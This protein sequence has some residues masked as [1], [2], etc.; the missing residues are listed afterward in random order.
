MIQGCYNW[1]TSAV[2]QMGCYQMLDQPNVDVKN[3]VICIC[4]Q[5]LCNTD[6]VASTVA[7]TAKTFTCQSSVSS[8]TCQGYA[9]ITKYVTKADSNA[10]TTVERKCQKAYQYVDILEFSEII[11]D[12]QQTFC[13]TDT[14]YDLGVAANEVECY[15][16]ANDCNAPAND[17]NLPKLGFMYTDCKSEVCTTAGCKSLASN[18]VCKGQFCYI[19]K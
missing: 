15:C 12:T 5:T 2:K 13:V 14:V 18:G 11:Q 19:G 17:V 9:C 3:G 16:Y 10:S 1:T 7:N 8:G 4:N 6:Q